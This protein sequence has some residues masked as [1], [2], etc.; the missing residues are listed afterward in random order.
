MPEATG[1]TNSHEPYQGRFYVAVFPGDYALFP[2]PPAEH[3][4][5]RCI[6]VQGRI[7]RYRGAPQIV[8]RGPEDVRVL[9]D[10]GGA[11]AAQGPGADVAETAEPSSAADA[12]DS[13]P[14]PTST[15]NPTPTPAAY[16][17]L[18]V[19][20]GAAADRP[21]DRERAP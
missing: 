4:R 14:N 11:V 17:G 1:W 6:V 2:A 7:E 19:A 5:G 16:N 20:P 8:L 9:A 12:L 10:L 21:R 13:T 3:F 18:E 15:H